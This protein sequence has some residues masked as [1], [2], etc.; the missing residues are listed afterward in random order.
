[1]SSTQVV[2]AGYER[3][4]NRPIVGLLESIGVFVQGDRFGVPV[5]AIID[6][7]EVSMGERIDLQVGCAQELVI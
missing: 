6:H 3:G 4:V 5:H 1:M 7:P 2:Q